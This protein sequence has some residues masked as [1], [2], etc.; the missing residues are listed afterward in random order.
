[1][2]TVF[3]VKDFQINNPNYKIIAGVDADGNSFT[4][5]MSDKGLNLCKANR[6]MKARGVEFHGIIRVKEIHNV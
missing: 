5:G 6:I 3:G 4:V 1:M 2:G